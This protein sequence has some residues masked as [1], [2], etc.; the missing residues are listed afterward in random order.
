MGQYHPKL[1]KRM[2][3]RNT[4]I[5]G[6]ILHRKQRDPWEEAESTDLLIA[7]RGKGLRAQ[8]YWKQLYGRRLRAQIY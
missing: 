3:E 5:G 4:T 7:T 2:L 6:D 8:I 1:K